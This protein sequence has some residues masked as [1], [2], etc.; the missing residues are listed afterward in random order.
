MMTQLEKKLKT[1][2]RRF[3]I[4]ESD[5]V[6]AAVSGGAG[7]A[8]ML[9]SLARLRLHGQAFP[10]SILVAHLNHQLRGEESDRD[11]AFVKQLAAEYGLPVFISSIAVADYAQQTKR[12]LEATARQLRYDFLQRV[13]ED[14][15]ACFVLTAHTRDDQAET[16]LMRLLRG[17]G[18]EGLRGVH[19]IR[20]LGPH[21]KLVRPLLEVSRAEVVDHCTQYGIKF[22]TDSSNLSDDLTR[23]RIRQELLPLLR[24]FNPRS[25]EALVRAAAIVAEDEDHLNQMSEAVLASS[26]NNLNE[27]ESAGLS[28]VHLPATH[29]AIRRRVLRLWLRNVR[30]SLRRIDSKHLA[31]IERLILT[32]QS[33]H[34]I[35][36]PDH[37]VVRREFDV[38]T[39]SQS[40]DNKQVKPT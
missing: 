24:T 21:V 20:P 34:S 17:S 18:A 38:L 28:I 7:S 1:A 14:S 4:G 16:V 5:S 29:N 22:R 19:P 23:N 9:D 12:N 37:W 33:G 2:L 40:S 11:E 26:I 35:E 31:A 10:R 36:L 25:E 27:H 30:G 3:G 8:A 6:V 32:R 13:A 15:G 39:L